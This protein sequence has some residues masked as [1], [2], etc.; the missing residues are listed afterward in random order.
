MDSGYFDPSFIAI[1]GTFAS[2]NSDV[3]RYLGLETLNPLLQI[4]NSLSFTFIPIL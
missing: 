2:F 1:I 4:Q 3:L